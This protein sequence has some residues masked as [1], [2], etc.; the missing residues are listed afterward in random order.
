LD[1]GPTEVT[2]VTDADGQT[3]WIEMDTS[4]GVEVL[5]NET[6][7]ASGIAI[8]MIEDV[9]PPAL[10]D[11]TDEI[12][13]TLVSRT[14]P[15]AVPIV[16]EGLR[17]E[18]NNVFPPRGDFWHWRVAVPKGSTLR[19]SAHIASL[20]DGESIGQY[21]RYRGSAPDPSS[22]G[23]ST[24]YVRGVV[25][26]VPQV[27]L[28]AEGF[29]V[30][31]SLLG[32][33]TSGVVIDAYNF[34]SAPNDVPTDAPLSVT[35]ER[36]QNDVAYV[37]VRGFLSCGQLALLARCGTAP[38]ARVILTRDAPPSV[39]VPDDGGGGT[40]TAMLLDCVDCDGAASLL[41]SD[42]GT[43]TNC[44]PEVPNMPPGWT[45]SPPTPATNHCGAAATVGSVECHVVRS[46]TAR[47]CRNPGTTVRASHGKTARWKVTFQL[48]GGVGQ[49]LSSSSG[50]EYGQESTEVVTDEW[51][52]SAGAYGLGQCL[53]FFRFEL[54]CAQAFALQSDITKADEYGYA[55]PFPCA[56]SSLSYSV[57]TDSDN[58]SSVCDR[59][60]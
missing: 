17:D 52:A 56:I 19:F 9:T 18:V 59:T 41:P 25:L 29:I 47:M 10:N 14:Q 58:S 48:N 46:R 1:G 24:S 8:G 50:F 3:P 31:L 6:S 16:V 12:R 38:P 30:G 15:L 39:V 11:P 33:C 28:G 43:V 27:R 49:P 2:T 32:D 35:L 37:R 40:D 57:C 55:V 23:V 34:V 21:L 53:R 13:Y 5:L 45:C 36:V 26:V 4:D 7:T 60:P 20:L 22:S 44:E 51:T 54:V 42:P